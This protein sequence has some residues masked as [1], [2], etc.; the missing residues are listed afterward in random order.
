[1][2]LFVVTLTDFLVGLTSLYNKIGSP[3]GGLRRKKYVQSERL[4]IESC[5][6]FFLC[7]IMSLVIHYYVREIELLVCIREVCHVHHIDS[8]KHIKECLNGSDEILESEAN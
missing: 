7:K 4:I 2:D 8:Y 5:S 1:M 3:Y 6:M